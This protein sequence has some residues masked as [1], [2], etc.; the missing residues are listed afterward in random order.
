MY[1]PRRILQRNGSH[2]EADAGDHPE[3]RVLW[4]HLLA[5][6]REFSDKQS[7]DHRH[8]SAVLLAMVSLFLPS[9]WL[10]DYI[11]DPVGAMQT[12]GLRLSYLLLIFLAMAF[13][14]NRIRND[15]LR[16]AL[17]LILLLSEGVF[18]EILNRLHTGWTHGLGGFMYAMLLSVLAGQGVPLISA[19]GFTLV[20]ALLPHIMA[21]IGLSPD[22][23][24]LR[25]A[26][27]M[28]PAMGLTIL[29]Q[30]VL[31]S[32]YAKR[33]QLE[34]RLKALSNTDPLSGIANRRHFTEM[35]EREIERAR[36]FK[37]ILFVLML[38]IDHFK[39]I[40]DTYGHSVGDAVI[41]HVAD[42]LGESV[43]SIDGVGRIGGEEF[44]IYLSGLDRPSAQVVAERL[45]SRV[46]SS[47]THGA[48]GVFVTHTISIGMAELLAE[49]TSAE[50]LLI[51]A[52]KALYAAKNSGRNRVVCAKD[53][54][55]E[56]A[57]I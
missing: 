47:P 11:T 54:D 57:A 23:P 43:R 33:Y 37:Q 49:D 46:E 28:W 3:N 16:L 5:P 31:A 12:I 51:R 30:F 35:L 9:L 38:D 25:Y 19:V 32:E 13:R 10:W 41:C 52:D 20:A 24:H 2:R 56:G 17:P 55:C 7:Q 36:R 21:M 4:R 42:M 27:L 44:S 53:P 14:S 34:E 22:F 18:V 8:F 29:I 15:V 48:R 6:D 45:R 1:E 40:N 26:I 50:A 39:R